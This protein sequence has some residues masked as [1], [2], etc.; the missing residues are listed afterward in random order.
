MGGSFVAPREELEGFFYDYDSKCDG[1]AD[2]D[3]HETA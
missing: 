1:S 2:L 3:R